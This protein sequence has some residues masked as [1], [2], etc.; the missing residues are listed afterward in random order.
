MRIGFLI[1]PI[2]GMGGRV[3]LHGTDGDLLAHARERGAIPQSAD[4]ARSALLSTKGRF[5]ASHEIHAAPGILGGDLLK[6]LAIPFHPIELSRHEDRKNQDTTNEDTRDLVTAFVDREVDLILFA[7][8]DGTARDIFALVGDSIPMLGIPSGVKMRSGVFGLNPRDVSEIL[9][10]L[11][12]QAEPRFMA[13]EILDLGVGSSDY[14]ASEF[15]GVA[16]TPHAPD[17]IQRSKTTHATTSEAGLR[18][19]A[20]HYAK[21]METD[22]LYLIGPGGSTHLILEALFRDGAKEL[23]AAGVHAIR[24]RQL[25]GEDMSE[26]EILATVDKYPNSELAVG[27]IGGQGYLFGRGNQQLSAAVV[28]RIGWERIFI[29]ASSAKLMELLPVQLHVDFSEPLVNQP[30]QFMKVNTSVTRSVVC[31]LLHRVASPAKES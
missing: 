26:N 15:F 21:E 30:P 19:L 4:R 1:N 23:D 29:L 27:V 9:Q 7:G 14:S 2:A 17:L 13:A 6:E 31:R 16:R 22:R 3:G 10:R 24:N 12:S 5:A 25:I 18:E 8:G 11:L 20:I 28:D